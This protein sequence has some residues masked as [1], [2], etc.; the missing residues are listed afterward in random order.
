MSAKRQ[1]AAD[2]YMLSPAQSLL[3]YEAASPAKKAFMREVGSLIPSGHYMRHNG[4]LEA[5]PST[6]VPMDDP[7]WT[8]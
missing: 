4:N 3:K 2:G 6:F 7:G 8:K 1:V 5:V